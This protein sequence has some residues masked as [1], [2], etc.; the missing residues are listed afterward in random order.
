M[1]ACAEGL[2]KIDATF[3]RELLSLKCVELC[4]RI[5]REIVAGAEGRIPKGKREESNN[6]KK[7][8]QLHFLEAPCVC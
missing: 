2:F 1:K 7:A 5:T 6:N 8:L 4:D 3:A